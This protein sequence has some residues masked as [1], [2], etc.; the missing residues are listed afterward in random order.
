MAYR[1]ERFPD[2]A[3]ARAA[4]H[5]FNERLRQ[6]GV[7]EFEL[8]ES[9]FSSYRP[10]GPGKLIWQQYFLAMDE[11]AEGGLEVRGGYMLQFQGYRRADLGFS[12]PYGWLR[13]PLSEG[14]VNKRFA[15]LGMLIVRDAMK[16]EP[17]LCSLGMGGIHRPLPRLMAGLGWHVV[18][19]PFHFHV[20]HPAA[21]LRNIRILR[22]R[23]GMSTVCDIARWSGLGWLG[24]KVLQMRP[25][26]LRQP[27][28]K[29]TL[30]PAFAGW[31]DA[32]WERSAAHYSFCAER[33]AALLDTLYEVEDP[34]WI[35][36]VVWRQGEPVGWALLLCSDVR[37]HKQFGNMRLG[38]IADC[39]SAP[40]DAELVVRA[41]MAELRKRGADIIVTNQMHQDWNRALKRSGF[42]S[43]PSNFVWALSPAS[44]KHFE[45]YSHFVPHAH[46]NRGDGD[47]PINL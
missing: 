12:K 15:A 14:V 27:D 2:S 34:R 3:E 32:V 5:R 17:L 13:L 36:C 8:M 30:E 6:G 25:P 22:Q 24:L 38:S 7:T 9:T 37:D 26:R 1:I 28:I 31:A 44:K 16:R 43:G 4:A 33:T 47:G 46:I 10:E 35:R 41:A 19:V 29:I 20:L 42:L 39:L 23:R 21:F 40:A 45:P 18:E 11:P